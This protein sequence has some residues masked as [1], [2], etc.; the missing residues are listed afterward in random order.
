MSDWLRAFTI[1]RNRRKRFAEEW[2][3]HLDVAAAE[4]ESLG[5]TKREARTL[6]KRRLGNR[7][8]HQRRALRQI[9]GDLNGLLDLLPLRSFIRSALLV[10][11]TLVILSTVALVFNPARTIALKCLEAVIVPGVQPHLE[12]WIP[13]TPAGV[14]PVDAAGLVLRILVILGIMR[15]ALGLIPRAGWRLCVYAASVLIAVAFAAAVCWITVL[16]VLFAR[17]WAHDGIQGLALIAF[18]F[19]FAGM[20]YMATH[21]WWADVERRCPVCLRVPGMQEERGK[22][23]HVLIE[24]LEVETICLHGHGLILKNRWLRHFTAAQPLFPQ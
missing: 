24:P 17:T 20:L 13:S 11:M 14:V 15:I 8:A 3:F 22:F 12:H 2:N 19:G 5:F 1:W 16:Q 6:A 21:L 4:G 18:G 7:Y 10:P 23:H 9:G